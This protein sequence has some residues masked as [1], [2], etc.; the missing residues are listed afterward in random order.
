MVKTLFILAAV[1]LC[2]ERRPNRPAPAQFDTFHGETLELRCAFEGFGVLPFGEGADVRLWYQTNG[3][4]AAWWS[5]PATVASNTVAAAWPPS[6]DPGAERVAFF[7]GA[8]SNAYAAAQV[9]FR[10]SPGA[11]PNVLNPPSVLD[12]ADGL[13]AVSNALMDYVDRKIVNLTPPSYGLVSNLAM[14]AIQTLEPAS[15]HTDVAVGRLHDSLTDGEITVAKA[16]LSL[17]SDRSSTAGGADVAMGLESNGEMRT[18]GDIFAAID[19]KGDIT[20]NDVCAIVTNMVDALSPGWHLA[21]NNVQVLDC[22]IKLIYYVDPPHTYRSAYVYAPG[23]IPPAGEYEEGD[24]SEVM[25][26][27]HDILDGIQTNATEITRILGQSD[28]PNARYRYLTGTVATLTRGVKRNALGLAMIWEIPTNNTQLA[29]GRGFVTASIT[30]DL[31][32]Q[33]SVTSAVEQLREN[34]TNGTQTV[35]SAILASR[36]DAA[37]IADEALSAKALKTSTDIRTAGDIFNDI[38][39]LK[40]KPH[41]GTNAVASIVAN[42]GDHLPFAAQVNF[43][44]KMFYSEDIRADSF[45]GMLGWADYHDGNGD[46][47]QSALDRKA[48]VGNV[49]TKAALEAVSNDAQVVYRLFS[50]SNVVDEVT[51]YNSQVRLPS[52]RLYQL[53]TNGYHMVWNELDQHSN[54]LA[55]A[56]AYADDLGTNYAQR[57][58]SRTTAMYGAEAPSNT[59][60]ISTP[61][62]VIAAGYEYQKYATSGGAIWVLTSRGASYEFSPNTNNTAFLNIAAQDGTPIFRIEKTDSYLLGVNASAIEVE[63][64]TMFVDVNIAAASHP[65][66]RVCEHLG[67]G[68]Q[69]EEDGISASLATVNWSQTADGYRCAIANNTGGSSLFAYFEYLQEGGVKIVN[70]GLL[71][72]SGGLIVNGTIYSRIG[73]AMISGHTVLTLEP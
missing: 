60:W 41:I 23:Y 44:D 26:Y 25:F 17:Y 66:V 43:G 68:W 28:I 42:L 58:W 5:V 54:T 45:S 64:D 15:N 6:A 49:A 34:L 37:T 18:A 12:W 3:M 10:N 72:I 7:F 24:I 21:T 27:I 11:T 50:G 13:A 48:D 51:N 56:K 69:K 35:A 31:A 70:G 1:P 73:T 62:T 38:D 63:N 19:A 29:N 32:R 40:A 33:S 2:W 71:D 16:E 39:S 4:G 67:D 46:N 30:N 47:L 57:A 52:R 53:D 65:F 20:T 55:Q 36:A 61:T 9:R 59:T 14:S 8:P 22:A